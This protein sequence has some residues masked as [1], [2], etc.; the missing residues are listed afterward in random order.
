MDAAR[1]ANTIGDRKGE[2]ENPLKTADRRP[3]AFG[4]MV[5]VILLPRY[6]L[7]HRD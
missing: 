7:N 2:A 6:L 5:S 3:P 4:V 1:C